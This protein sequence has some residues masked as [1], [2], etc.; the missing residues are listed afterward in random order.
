M[1][2]EAKS[3]VNGIIYCCCDLIRESGNHNL[4]RLT[5]FILCH[6]LKYVVYGK[7]QKDSLITFDR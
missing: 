4:L 7:N 1:V 2:C 5:Y 6:K 3:I